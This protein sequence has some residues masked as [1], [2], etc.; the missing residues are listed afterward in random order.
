MEPMLA[1]FE[2]VADSISFN[3]PFI[4]LISNVTGEIVT[5]EITT[6]QYW[7][8]HVRQPV[9]FSQS[10]SC[11]KSLNVDVFIEIGAKPILL[12]MGRNCLPEHRGLWLPSLRSVSEDCKQMLSSLA[13][14]YVQGIAIDWVGFDGDYERYREP[15]PTYPFNRQRY[16]VEAPDWYRNGVLPQHNG[17][18]KQSDRKTLDTDNALY[19]INWKRDLKFHLDSVNGNDG[20]KEGNWLIFADKQ[21]I[22]EQL[23]LRIR[24]QGESCTLVKPGS[25]Y[26]QIGEQECILNPLNLQHFQKLL[27]S[28]PQLSQVVHLW[29]LDIP[30][31]TAQKDL[32]SQSQLSCG[33]TL[34]LVQALL[35]IDNQPPALWLVTQGSQAIGDYPVTGV[36]QS[37]LWGMG[38]ALAIEHP[39]LNCVRLD[40]NPEKTGDEVNIIWSEI[41][42]SLK[43]QD[44]EDQIAWRDNR[45][46]VPRLSRRNAPETNGKSLGIKAD[47]TYLITGGLGALGLKV[48]NWLVEKGAKNLVLLGRSKPKAAVN[49]Q[50]AQMEQLG[51][52]VVVATAD[53]SAADQ[54]STVF[55]EIQQNMPPF[56][57]CDI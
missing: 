40:L 6:A 8:R 31:A 43:S 33:S 28:L 1:D 50:L 34:H 29:S 22:G 12:G 24:S 39:E 9:R 23:A 11:V 38:K 46:Y 35:G 47:G 53:V 3:V 57:A 44:I 45:R 14:L 37:P 10:M 5:Q 54:L 27:Q 32:L 30:E 52:K 42:H 48:A 16:W 15:L 21:G 49:S 7:C 20:K 2:R 36:A 51:V 19:Q 55:N 56:M 17:N 13:E 26:Q 41:K 25:E 4:E 18:S